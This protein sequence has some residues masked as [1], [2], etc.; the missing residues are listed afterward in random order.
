[1]RSLFWASNLTSKLS[2]RFFLN[3]LHFHESDETVAI[4]KHTVT[5]THTELSHTHC[6]THI[7]TDRKSETVVR[8]FAI[9]WTTVPSF[10]QSLQ[11]QNCNV[12]L[13]IH[14]SL[15][16]DSRSWNLPEPPKP[17]HSKIPLD[18]GIYRGT[19]VYPSVFD[20]PKTREGKYT[21]IPGCFRAPSIFPTIN[22][23]C[24]LQ[25]LVWNRNYVKEFLLAYFFEY[26]ICLIIQSTQETR[27]HHKF[28][29][30][31]ERFE[32]SP[33]MHQICSENAASN[34]CKNNYM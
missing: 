14:G 31:E 21:D 2:S 11:S 7:F 23:V 15:F 8:T 32:Y 29:T 9:Q 10:F 13:V 3:S 27:K 20:H 1:M 24:K 26:F 19:F 5:R 33:R 4:H 22:G 18:F 30:Q 25:H 34:S 28:K 16:S 17:L 6:Q 12:L